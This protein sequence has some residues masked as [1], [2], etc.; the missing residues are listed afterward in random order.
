MQ[1]IYHI[2]KKDN[3]NKYAEADIQLSKD[4]L[5][6]LDEAKKSD[7]AVITSHK[8]AMF[9]DFGHDTLIYDEDPMS[10]LLEIKQ[11]KITDLFALNMIVDVPQLNYFIEDLQKATPFKLMETPNY[12]VNIDKLVE[13]ISQVQLVGNIF[14]F[15]NSCYYMRD[16]ATTEDRS[17]WRKEIIHYIV[18]KDLPTDKKVIIMSAT[19]SVPIYQK[20]FGDRL[21]VKNIG[22]VIQKGTITQHT[23]RSCSRYGLKRYGNKISEEVG[24][25]PVITFKIHGNTFNNAVDGIWFGNCSGYDALKGENIAVV[26]TPHVNPLQYFLTAKALGI[27]VK[28]KDMTMSYQKIE[29][30]GFRFK[31]NCFDN[32]ELREIQLSIIEAEL[33]QAVGRARTLREKDASVQLY[34]NFPLRIS[35]SFNF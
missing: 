10:S 11:M 25:L 4:Y 19:A 8:R 16:G 30:N 24:D 29:Y 33:I 1:L 27:D 23:K 6:E 21:V 31:F 18:K 35:D 2:V 34:S 17:S 5:K 9:T 15:F 14:D 32:E 7:E 3:T 26:G 20:M 28:T 12:S 13:I 22:D